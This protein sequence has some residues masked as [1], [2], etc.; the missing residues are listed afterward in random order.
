MTFEEGRG[1]FPVLETVAYLNAGTFGPLAE[2]VARAEAESLE[3][4]L[5]HGRSGLAYLEETLALRAELRGAFASLV[6]AE[7]EQLALTASTTDG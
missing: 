7:V 3:H 4:D 1:L 6:G 2:P 5:E